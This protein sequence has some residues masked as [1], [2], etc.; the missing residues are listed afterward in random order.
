M[1]FLM[2]LAA[3]CMPVSAY[4]QAIS[5]TRAAPAVA[6]GLVI[7]PGVA[8]VTGIN[9]TTGAA[10]GYVMVFDSATIPADG[11]V[12]PARCLPVAANTGIDINFRGSPLKFDMG[13]VVVFSTTGCYTKTASATAFIAGDIQ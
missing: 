4:G 12:T 7:K 5:R 1:R 9:V 13:A 10:A 6:G 3:L 11:A 2:A 8:I